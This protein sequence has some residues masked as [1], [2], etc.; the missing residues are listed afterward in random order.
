MKYL[1]ALAVVLT[2]CNS[3]ITQLTIPASPIPVSKATV[4]P[5]GTA[6]VTND[7]PPLVFFTSEPG[8]FQVWLPAS[9]SVQQYTATI[10]LLGES[11]DCPIL[12]FTLNGASATV[13]YCNLDPKSIAVLSQDEILEQAPDQIMDDIRAKLEAKQRIIVQ[14]IYPALELSG[15]VVM[16]GMGYDGTFKARL[17]L[18]HKRIY[19]VVMSV[20]KENWC[21]CLHQTDRVVA[22]LYIEPGLSIPFEATP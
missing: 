4:L 5:A 17:I 22:S 9:G 2:A 10:T 1:F 16:R 20:Y 3:A 13:E 6:N 14:D 8:E 7:E 19:L 12:N 11:I 21:N 18:A 15:P